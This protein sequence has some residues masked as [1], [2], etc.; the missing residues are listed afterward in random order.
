MIAS[1]P[2]LVVTSSL[3]APATPQSVLKGAIDHYKTLKSFSMTIQHQDSSGLFPG[4]YT[5][6]LKWRK[7]DA[8]ELVMTKKSDFKETPGQP[9]LPAPNF[10]CRDG[11]TVDIVWPQRPRES[12]ELTHDA[13]TSPGWEVSGGLIMS[14]LLGSPDA[15]IIFNMPPGYKVT[16]SF[17]AAKTW[18][19]EAV[20][21]VAVHAEMQLRADDVHYYVSPDGKRLVGF[22]WSGGGPNPGWA[23]YLKQVENPTLPKS[24]GAAPK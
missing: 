23:H 7:R 8:F 11:A 12:R 20:T 13:N 4:S 15:D 9:G 2:I 18:Q 5:Q 1:I 17:G 10:Y 3:L 21:D 22:S 24:L 16:W 6:S 19:G 14:A